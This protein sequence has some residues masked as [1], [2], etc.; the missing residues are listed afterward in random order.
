MKDPTKLVLLPIPKGLPKNILPNGKVLRR[1]TIILMRRGNHV[2]KEGKKTDIPLF[3]GI[4][5]EIA[6]Q[7]Q[8]S[9]ERKERGRWAN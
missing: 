8:I 6:R 2:T 4:H 3:R 9:I 7:E 1:P 5:P